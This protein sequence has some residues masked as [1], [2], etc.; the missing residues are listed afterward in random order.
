MTMPKGWVNP[1]KLTKTR[2]PNT[3]D[4]IEQ[5]KW[6]FN[7]IQNSIQNRY[8]EIQHL[9]ENII[10]KIDKVYPE[11]IKSSRNRWI[12]AIAFI[13]TL[14]I[15]LNGL[16]KNGLFEFFGVNGLIKNG[17]FES[18]SLILTIV[19]SLVALVIYVYKTNQ[20]ERLII[21]SSQIEAGYNHPQHRLSEL[22]ALISSMS[23]HPERYTPADLDDL[24][25]FVFFVD[26]NR[27]ELVEALKKAKG[28]PKVFEKDKDLFGSLL[29]PIEERMRRLSLKYKHKFGPQNQLISHMYYLVKEII[30]NYS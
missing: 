19:L 23:M 26:S 5:R 2:Q 7:C 9:R 28:D 17:L 11:E 18:I 6:M 30:E 3:V 25:D 16:I 21:I 12:G 27:L 14:L 8:N 22:G 15:S 4:T 20:L 13:I 24:F 1:E 10:P 29:E